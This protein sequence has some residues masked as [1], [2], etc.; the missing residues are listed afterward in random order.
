MMGKRWGISILAVITLGSAFRGIDPAIATVSDVAATEPAPQQPLKIGTNAFV[1]FVMIDA[2]NKVTGG[3]SVELWDKLS[4]K[5]GVDYEFVVFDTLPALLKA[6]EQQQVDLAMAGISITFEREQYL[7]FS[8]SYYETGLGIMV[9][10]QG[11]LPWRFLVQFLLSKETLGAVGI[12]LSLS[13]IAGNLLWFSE[14]KKNPDMFPQRYLPGIWEAF[15][16]S[17]VTA[18]TVGYGDKYPVSVAGRLVSLVWMFSG[19]VL[20]AQFTAAI[21]AIRLEGRINGFDDLINKRVAVTQG[22]TSEAYLKNYPIRLMKVKKLP[23]ALTLLKEDKV[24]AVVNDAAVL[25]YQAAQ[26]PDQFKVV[27]RLFAL[28]EYGIALPTGRYE[29]IEQINR[30]LLQFRE[31][32][33]LKELDQ[34]WFPDA[35]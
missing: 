19:L 23:E 17:M 30:L 7:D 3:Y 5:L 22:T 6:V 4:Q 12:L 16:W 31:D 20:V 35:D 10:K 29:E 21:T 32:D 27:G 14:R 9:R 15:W 26:E 18:T 8:H 34:K 28:Q 33:T 13:F 24:D 2:E 25:L 1:P 11:V